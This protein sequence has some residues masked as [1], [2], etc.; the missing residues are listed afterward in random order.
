M[1]GTGKCNRPTPGLEEVWQECFVNLGFPILA[2][3]PGSAQAITYA[4]KL[5]KTTFKNALFIPFHTRQHYLIKA[6]LED[7]N[8]QASKQNIQRISKEINRFP[9]V[10]NHPLPNFQGLQ[11]FIQEQQQD[12]ELNHNEVVDERCR[13]CSSF[14]L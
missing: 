10:Q 12:L 14:L 13:I 6:W 4:A 7:H 2:P 5:M 11:Q 1:M 9:A 8:Y 3:L